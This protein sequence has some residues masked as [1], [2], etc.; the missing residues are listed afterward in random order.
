M[1]LEYLTCQHIKSLVLLTSQCI[2][3][4]YELPPFVSALHGKIVHCYD[5]ICTWLAVLRYATHTFLTEFFKTS[6]IPYCSCKFFTVVT[7][8]NVFVSKS[9]LLLLMNVFRHTLEK[10]RNIRRKSIKTIKEFVEIYYFV[11]MYYNVK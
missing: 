3:N 1:P 10:L 11:C 7:Q 5:E 2:R 6:P 8:A 9:Q 4:P